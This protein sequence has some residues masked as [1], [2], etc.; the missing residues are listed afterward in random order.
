MPRTPNANH[1]LIGKIFGRLKVLRRASRYKWTARCEC[2]SV[3]NYLV[4]NLLSSKSTQCRECALIRFQHLGAQGA[5]IRGHQR[6]YKI[7]FRA[8]EEHGFA[9]S[10]Q[11]FETFRDQM[12]QLRTEAPYEHLLVPKNP[13]KPISENNF[14]WVP[15]YKKR[16]PT[17]AKWITYNDK[18]QNLTEWAE[19]L[20]ITK[21]ALS[22]RLRKWPLSRAMLPGRQKAAA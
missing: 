16:G 15:K 2:G 4:F 9:H 10:W 21:M 12:R 8:K 11:Q 7:W 20:G 5:I 6:I 22:I 13:K 3:H 18:T 17:A 14:I 1:R 19:E